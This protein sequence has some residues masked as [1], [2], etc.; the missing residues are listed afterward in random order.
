[1]LTGKNLPF[2]KSKKT[3]EKLPAVKQDKAVVSLL[4]SQD[5]NLD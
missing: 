4:P 5:S 3:G 1:M 2:F